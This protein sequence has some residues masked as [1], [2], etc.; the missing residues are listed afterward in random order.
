MYVQ[1]QDR[2]FKV[3]KTKIQIVSLFNAHFSFWL[4]FLE[5][6]IMK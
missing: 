3:T 4:G 1:I 2:S 6:N 5:V